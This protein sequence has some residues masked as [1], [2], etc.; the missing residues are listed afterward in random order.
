MIDKNVEIIL[1]VDDTDSHNDQGE[2]SANGC[3]NVT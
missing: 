2:N 1:K 3:G